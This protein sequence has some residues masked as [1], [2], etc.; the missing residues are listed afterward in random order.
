M[1]PKKDY[2]QGDVETTRAFFTLFRK[3]G[4][5]FKFPIDGGVSNDEEVSA[6]LLFDAE[7]F[8]R[9][10]I[11]VVSINDADPLT[12]IVETAEK[13]G[14]QV[15]TKIEENEYESVGDDYTAHIMYAYAP[16]GI[17]AEWNVPHLLVY[18]SL[19]SEIKNCAYLAFGNSINT[20][21]IRN[22]FLVY[23]EVLEGED[24][25]RSQLS[26]EVQKSDAFFHDDQRFYESNINT[27][28]LV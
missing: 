16:S 15:T 7:E 20:A 26:A 22:H 8:G 3:C 4:D 24:R 10:V 5:L 23:G 28:D 21:N 27:A 9:D 18:G 13:M 17:N 11:C 1:N 19:D 6:R 25:I 14:L 2:E 12:E